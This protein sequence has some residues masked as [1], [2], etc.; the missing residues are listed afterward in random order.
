MIRSQNKYET[1]KKQFKK[2]RK[3]QTSISLYLPILPELTSIKTHKNHGFYFRLLFIV[4]SQ[5]RMLKK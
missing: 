3:S 4:I 5:W 1:T 2:D